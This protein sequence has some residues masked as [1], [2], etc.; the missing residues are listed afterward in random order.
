MNDYE[1]WN[2]F[3]ITKYNEAWIYNIIKTDTPL[4]QNDWIHTQKKWLITHEQNTLYKTK[5]CQVPV[6]L[7]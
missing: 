4:R 1:K 6:D 5:Y 7:R 3:S 2:G